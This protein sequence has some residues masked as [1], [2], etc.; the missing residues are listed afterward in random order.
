MKALLFCSLMV[1]TLFLLVSFTAAQGGPENPVIVNVF[2]DKVP[3]AKG[4]PRPDKVAGKKPSR[5]VQEVTKPTLD[6]VSS[7]QR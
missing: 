7:R 1:T 6:G 2:P 3:G 5:S 4:D